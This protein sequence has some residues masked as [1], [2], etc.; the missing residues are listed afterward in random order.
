[1][2]EW[3]ATDYVCS[4]CA[5]TNL[6]PVVEAEETIQVCTA[7]GRPSKAMEVRA[8]A[9]TVYDAFGRFYEPAYPPPDGHEQDGRHPI[10]V[11]RSLIG[12]N[13]PEGLAEAITSYLEQQEKAGTIRGGGPSLFNPSGH[14]QWSGRA[15]GG[16]AFNESWPEF[17]EYVLNRGR[18]F[19]PVIDNYLEGVL[20]DI[21]TALGGNDA[22]LAVGTTIYRARL[23]SDGQAVIKAPREQL[24]PPP[25]G[26]RSGGRLNGLIYRSVQVGAEVSATDTRNIAIFDAEGIVEGTGRGGG[27]EYQGKLQVP[28]SETRLR[29]LDGSLKLL[30]TKAADYQTGEVVDMGDYLIDADQL[31]MD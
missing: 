4:A 10:E 29:Y 12:T 21:K 28:E 27:H 30:R 23:V 22:E 19:D 9:A 20:A 7:C 13:V 14:Y 25:R 31:Y 8:I 26:V 6:Q 17:R 2:P 11:V 1:M 5:G 15:I 3:N 16:H 24:G 18:Y